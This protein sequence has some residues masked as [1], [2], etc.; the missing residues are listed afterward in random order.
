MNAA[1][2]AHLATGKIVYRFAVTNG[3][4]LIGHILE[5]DTG[6]HQAVNADGELIGSYRTRNEASKAISGV[7][8]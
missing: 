5:T 7:Q 1:I 4:E 8:A 3:R 2:D 6:W